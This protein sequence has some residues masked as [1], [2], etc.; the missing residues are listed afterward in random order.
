MSS[1]TQTLTPTQVRSSAQS[2][3]VSLP[4]TPVHTPMRSRARLS[5]QDTDLHSGLIMS[6]NESLSGES[7]SDAMSNYGSDDKMSCWIRA[8]TGV[9]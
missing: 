7:S 8:I 9:K 2:S 6:S 3:T 5:Q 4:L 1:P